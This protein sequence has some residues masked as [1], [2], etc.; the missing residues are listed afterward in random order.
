[1][2]TSAPTH[3]GKE[4]LSAVLLAFLQARRKPRGGTVSTLVSCVTAEVVDE[5]RAQTFL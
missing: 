4:A 3:P 1:M 5:A 2:T